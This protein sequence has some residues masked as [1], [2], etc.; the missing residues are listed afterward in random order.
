MNADAIIQLTPGEHR[1]LR[2]L[3][4]GSDAITG[5]GP[6]P[7][8]GYLVDNG[9]IELASVPTSGRGCLR[10]TSLAQIIVDTCDG[11]PESS[12][13]VCFTVQEPLQQLEAKGDQV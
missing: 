1:F 5:I 8:I 3:C 9:L 2:D 12:S 11:T 4:E 13:L 6:C 10:A 7:R